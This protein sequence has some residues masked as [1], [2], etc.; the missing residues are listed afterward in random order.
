MAHPEY[1]FKFKPVRSEEELR[2]LEDIVMN[3]RIYATN[4]DHL[5]DPLESM[6]FKIELAV[7]G[8]GY[9]YSCGHEHTIVLEEKNKYRIL[10]LSTDV[11]SPLMW[12]HYANEQRGACLMFK[13]NKTFKD[14]RPIE[15]TDKVKIFSEGD[16]PDFDLPTLARESLF[17]KMKVWSYEK[18]WRLV[19]KEQP[20]LIKSD[21]DE[22]AAVIVGYQMPWEKRQKIDSWC[23]ERKTPCFCT[24]VLQIDSRIVFFPTEMKEPDFEFGIIRNE[25]EKIYPDCV[26]SLFTWLN[27]ATMNKWKWYQRV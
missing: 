26:Y 25:V 18:E 23:K 1:F 11:H 15:Y 27:E 9:A 16:T 17:V 21:E 4:K 24:S 22:L 2:R 12:A 13:G 19:E 3:N 5:N 8:G 10:S 7:V 20:G 14:A 6:S